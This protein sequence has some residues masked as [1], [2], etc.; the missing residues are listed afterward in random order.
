MRNRI[1][2]ALIVAFL[3]YLGFVA[4]RVV[5]ATTAAGSA[6]F[7]V[8]CNSSSTPVS[9]IPSGQYKYAEMIN[10]DPSGA[11]AV[12]IF[13]YT[14]TLPGSPPA[15]CTSAG[16]GAGCVKLAAGQPFY[17]SYNYFSLVNP[18]AEPAFNDGIA[19]V[20]ASGGSAVAVSGYYR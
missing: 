6:D 8:N 9:L 18:F 13:H 10:P 5:Q 20:F 16:S 11:N 12:Y 19:C 1:K 7:N 2:A 15:N 3:C 17:D 14:G 4:A